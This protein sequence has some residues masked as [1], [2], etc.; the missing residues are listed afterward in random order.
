MVYLCRIIH[1]TRK[2]MANARITPKQKQIFEA[3][4]NAYKTGNWDY[5]D[6]FQGNLADVVNALNEGKTI[7][8]FWEEIVNRFVSI[9]SQLMASPELFNIE[10]SAFYT[11]TRK[12]FKVTLTKIGIV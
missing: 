1:Q 6:G 9:T 3:H 8:K 11:D 5:P 4:A 7:K 12:G 10:T 2:K